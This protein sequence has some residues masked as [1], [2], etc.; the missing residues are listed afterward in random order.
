MSRSS[1]D[2]RS[3]RE[4][5]RREIDGL[6][7]FKSVDDKDNFTSVWR[8]VPY[9]YS[10]AGC[11]IIHNIWNLT[12]YIGFRN[13]VNCSCSLQLFIIVDEKSTVSVHT[14][15]SKELRSLVSSPLRSY[16]AQKS[17]LF[18]AVPASLKNLLGRWFLFVSH[19]PQK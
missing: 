1:R 4:K 12:R 19:L 9:S 8:N 11:Y 6:I 7:P 15:P 10:T 17:L 13:V 5:F 2:C 3:Y 14:G 18:A 16:S